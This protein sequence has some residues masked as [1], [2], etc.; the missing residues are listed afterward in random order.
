VAKHAK[1]EDEELQDLKPVEL[2]AI[3]RDRGIEGA[4]YMTKPQALEAL[5]SEAHEGEAAQE[6]QA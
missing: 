5:R 2:R 3:A 4:D 1:K 6:T